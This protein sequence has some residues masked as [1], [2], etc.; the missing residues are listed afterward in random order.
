MVFDNVLPGKYAIAFFQDENGNQKLDT[1]F[2]GVPTEPFGFS[3]DVMGK[4]GPPSFEAAALDLPA[5]PVTV[6]MNA[7]YL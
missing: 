6:V 7:K 4:R 1:G 2:F 5:G 3:K